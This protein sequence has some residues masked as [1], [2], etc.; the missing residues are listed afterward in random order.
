[1]RAIVLQAQGGPEN[2][3]LEEVPEPVPGPGELLIRTEAIGVSYTEAALRGGNFPPP[4][5][6]PAVYGFEAAGTVTA[7]EDPSLIGKRVVS[8]N[9]A[10]GS[11]AEYTTAPLGA[12]TVV[13][14]G[15]SAADAVATANFGAVALTLLRA[16]NLTGSQ[17]V[18]IEAAAGGVGGY[19][20][21]LAHARGAGRVIA[22]AGTQ[23]KRDY[24]LSAGA[25]E[26]VDH[27]DPGW[28]EGLGK[29]RIDVVFESLAGQTT[30]RLVERSPRWARS[31]WC[32]ERG[33]C[34]FTGG[35]VAPGADAFCG[36]GG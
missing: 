20:T 31:S 36:A 32:R 14:D 6:L 18:L 16:A 5:T 3:T 27:G 8:M 30:V 26:V 23:P 21:Q 7:A 28:I 1:M 10:L 9:T 25:D 17:T 29:D 11:Y 4:V 12:V 15:V 22:T 19:L 2:L 33:G 24:A 35:G 34:M 13:P